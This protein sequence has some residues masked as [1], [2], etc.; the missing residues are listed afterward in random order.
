MPRRVQ[1][2]GVLNRRVSVACELGVAFGSHSQGLVPWT[3]VASE[4]P[5]A[6]RDVLPR[7]EPAIASVTET[8]ERIAMRTTSKLAVV[9]GLTTAGFV[10]AGAGTASAGCGI[11]LELHNRGTTAVTVDLADSDVKVSD[12]LINAW[13]RI[14]TGTRRVYGGDTAYETFT[15]D[16]GCNL[17]R[18]YRIEVNY[19]SDSWFVNLNDSDATV[20]VH[21]ER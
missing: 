9:A 8:G 5:R 21:I 7:E 1:A 17:F 13:K 20:H 12:W 6:H 4:N 16:F 14:D 11:T 15:A 18:S 3:R 2:Q 19:G 10:G